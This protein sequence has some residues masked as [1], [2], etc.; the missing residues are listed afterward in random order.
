M[1]QPGQ[2]EQIPPDPQEEIASLRK[3]VALLERRWMDVIRNS[4]ANTRT[5]DRLHEWTLALL[6]VDEKVELPDVLLVELM[7][8]FSIPQA[9]L[10]LWGLAGGEVFPGDVDAEVREWARGHPQIYCGPIFPTSALTWLDEPEG[11]ASV[12]LLPL[13]RSMLSMPFGLLVLGSDDPDRYRADLGVL[14]LQRIQEL[15]SAALIR[16]LPPAR[17]PERR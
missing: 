1:L 2:P 6:Q 7:E 5:A 9:A 14:H 4:Q 10:R 16:L 3:W 13:R 11:V 15:A 17:N 12:A 8:L